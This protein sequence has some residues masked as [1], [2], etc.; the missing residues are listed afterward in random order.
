MAQ[1]F[2]HSYWEERIFETAWHIDNI[3]WAKVLFE[4]TLKYLF[5]AICNDKVWKIDKV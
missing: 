4:V 5:Y 2:P 3:V 1:F